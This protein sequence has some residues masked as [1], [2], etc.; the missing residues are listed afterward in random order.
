[1]FAMFIFFTLQSTFRFYE[2]M[3][4]VH[5]LYV[6]FTFS[7]YVKMFAFLRL[8]SIFSFYMKISRMFHFPH[9]ASSFRFLL[10]IV[11]VFTLCCTQPSASM[12]KCLQSSPS[13][14]CIQLLCENVHSIYLLQPALNLLIFWEIFRH[15]HLFYTALKLLASTRKYLQYQLS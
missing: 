12:G 1:M 2:K 8:H 13:S 9:F 15:V 4:S 14:G 6:A 10:N 3:S 5:H 7:F 11:T